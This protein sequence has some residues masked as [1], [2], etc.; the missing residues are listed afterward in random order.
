[1]TNWNSGVGEFNERNF[2]N[3]KE[4]IYNRINQIEERFCELEDKSFEIIQLEENKEKKV[5]NSK[6][7]LGDLSTQD[8]IKGT[9][10]QT[11]RVPDGEERETVRGGRSAKCI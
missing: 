3:A 4:K 10:M 9:H 2:K 8:H 11:K 7:S 5:K 6:E 1:M